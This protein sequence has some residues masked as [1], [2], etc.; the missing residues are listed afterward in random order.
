MKFF[1]RIT[2]IRLSEDLIQKARKFAADVVDTTNYSDSNQYSKQ[3]INDDHFISKLGE[4]AA[5]LAFSL[6]A[7]I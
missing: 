4:E 1:K 6:Y 5:R 7:D 2:R 3:K